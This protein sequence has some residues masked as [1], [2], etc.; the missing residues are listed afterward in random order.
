MPIC[1]PNNTTLQVPNFL[2]IL[3]YATFIFCVKVQDPLATFI[4]VPKQNRKTKREFSWL[5]KMRS[6]KAHD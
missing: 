3:I 6:T 5:K 2:N 1:A 4:W